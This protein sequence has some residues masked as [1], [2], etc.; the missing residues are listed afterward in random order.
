MHQSPRGAS[1]PSEDDLR[2][3]TLAGVRSIA[4]SRV[5]AETLAFA[6]TVIVAR[7]VTPGQ[8]GQAALALVAWRVASLIASQGFTSPLVQRE[9]I[10]ESERS[11]AAVLSVGLGAVLGATL[12]FLGPVLG[13]VFDAEAGRMFQLISPVFV[14]AAFGAVPMADLQRA[15]DF[16]RL[17]A[18]EAAGAL[19]NA[20][21]ASGLA[22]AGLN[23]EAIVLG[24]IAATAATTALALGST[25]RTRLKLDRERAPALLRFGAPAAGSSLIY[26]TLRNVDYAIVGAQLSAT[27]L[28]IYARAYQLAVDYQGK[29]SGVMLRVA[30]PVY[31]RT[32]D[33]AAIRRV[34]VRIVRT[35]AT[36]LI[37][38]LATLAGVAPDLVPTVFGEQ[39]RAAVVPTQLLAISGMF[40]ATMTGTG[41]L[42]LAVG[43][44]RLLL[45]WN[46][47]MA[48]VYTGLVLAL[49]SQ[50][51][52]VLCIGV[53]VF[54]AGVF[55]SNQIVLKRVIGVGYRQTL[56]DAVAGVVAGAAAFGVSTI[57]REAV[58]DELLPQA[59]R[60][61]FASVVGIGAGG[62]LLRALFPAAWHDVSLI[63]TRLFRRSTSRP[64]P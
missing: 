55:I 8:F 31:S 5:A 60:L 36:V 37:P 16:R 32:P 58:G 9:E 2:T 41:P 48:V 6:S 28:G 38:L 61:V 33:L 64:S 27:Q 34:R 13:R 47:V 10:T 17:G 3:A 26:T 29:L 21:V 57:V 59:V 1:T 20:V 25:P 23:A 4:L 50:G 56:G 12:F 62:V 18:F 19:A 11:T 40:V 44:P 24:A 46:A 49:V 43:R 52:T 30:F 53:N 63:L 39:W 54:F 35:H 15:L 7:L 42:L 14:I 45:T 51:L 22:A